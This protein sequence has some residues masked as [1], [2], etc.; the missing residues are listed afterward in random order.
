MANDSMVYK[1]ESEEGSLTLTNGTFTHTFPSA[2]DVPPKVVIDKYSAS[3]NPVI[4]VTTTGFTIDG[5]DG[6]TAHFTV[7]PK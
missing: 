3:D 6:T 2:Y 7:I 5:Q 1:N 4:T